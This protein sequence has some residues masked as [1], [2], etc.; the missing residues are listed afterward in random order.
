[1]ACVEVSIQD[2][3]GTLLLNDPAR[4]NALSAHLIED[5]L[6]GLERLREQDARVVILR[7]A[8][9][10]KTWSAGHDVRELPTNGRDP[11]AYSDPLRHVIRDIQDFPAPVIALVEGGVWGGAC[12]V[13]MS[14]DMVIAAET[15]TFAITPARLGV[16]Y[17]IGGTLNLMQSVSLPIIKEML[18]RAKPISARQARD[19]GIVNHVVPAA[20]LDCA[21]AEMAADILVNSSLVITLLK[22]QLHVLSAATPLSAATFERLQGMRR[23]IY[24][25]RDYQEG[26]HAF[27]EKRAP[28]FTG[29]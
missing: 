8:P 22:E 3:V 2:A 11:L 10:V 12:E 14:C 21:A 16:P 17:N 20:E 7:A 15:A 6:A 1:M 19:A 27:F 9:G 28:H 29:H 13:V 23:A 5:L 26:I 24:D 18:F 25:S 4:R